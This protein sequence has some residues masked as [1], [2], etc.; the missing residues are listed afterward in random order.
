MREMA[1]KL[2]IL[3][4]AS[5]ELVAMMKRIVQDTIMNWIRCLSFNGAYHTPILN[6]TIGWRCAYTQAMLNIASILEQHN[7]MW[8]VHL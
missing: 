6:S 5:S 1:P 4:L 2:I 8:G 7:L 3:N